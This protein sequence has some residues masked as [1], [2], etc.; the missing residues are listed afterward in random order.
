MSAPAWLR[1]F[2]R[3]FPSGNMALVAGE[4]PILIDT[5][6]GSDAAETERLLRDAGTPPEALALVANTH[7]HCDHVGGNWMLQSR[8][9]VSIAASAW[10]AAIVNSRDPEACNADWLDQPIEPY[11][12]DRPLRDGDVLDAGGVTLVA[13]HTPGHTLGHLCFFAPDDRVLICGDAVHG[14]DVAWLTPYR[15]GIGALQRALQ[16]LDRLAAL[17][18]RW[19]C[20]GHGA[21]M[22]DPLAAFDAARR[23]YDRWLA[24]PTKLGWHACKR[25]FSYRLMLTDGM[26]ED[27]IA[28]YLL[29]QGWF[30]DYARHTFGH[31]PAEFVRPLLAELVR[32]G[33]CGWRDGRLY[34]LAPYVHNPAW[35]PAAPRPRDW[36]PV[37]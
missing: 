13:I 29:R 9:G 30:Q 27:E 10:D 16:T 20:S 25:I 7:Y 2:Q 14:D 23:R 26:P 19:A 28:P 17:A 11:T 21:P 5:G 36:P 37:S 22:Q 4:R 31:E 3:A 15:E 32:S 1:F 35:Q 24:D 12:V 6:F 8:H 33:A 18:P 34:A